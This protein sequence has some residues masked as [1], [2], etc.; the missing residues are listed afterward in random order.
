MHAPPHYPDPD[1]YLV[2]NPDGSYDVSQGDY[3]GNQWCVFPDNGSEIPNTR[4]KKHQLPADCDNIGKP[5][6]LIKQCHCYLAIQILVGE[7]W[8]NVL[9]E[10]GDY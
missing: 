2:C 9:P 10:A 1:A 5:I 4:T 3:N 8:L 7:M 6:P